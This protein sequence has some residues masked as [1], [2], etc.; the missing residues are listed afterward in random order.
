MKALTIP[1]PYASLIACG[2][3]EIESRH[4]PPPSSM[5]GETI[6]IHAGRQEILRQLSNRIERD[7]AEQAL[8]LPFKLWK[9]S[10]CF[11]SLVCTVTLLGAYEIHSY[12]TDSHKLLVTD[13]LTSGSPRRSGFYDVAFAH[14][15]PG[16]WAWLFTNPKP[17]GPYQHPSGQISPWDWNEEGMF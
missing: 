9:S 16:M 2:E 7:A 13:N 4:L 1:Q 3:K 6:A 14:C 5:I 8:G 17:I 15:Q 12:E 10:L 11:E